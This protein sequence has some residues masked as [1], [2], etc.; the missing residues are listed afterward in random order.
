MCEGEGPCGV[1]GPREGLSR[2]GEE[3]RWRVGDVFL[4]LL[5]LEWLLK[6]SISW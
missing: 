4:L 1:V 5:L 2:S 6:V 3:V